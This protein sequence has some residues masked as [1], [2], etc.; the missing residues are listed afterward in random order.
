MLFAFLENI[1]AKMVKIQQNWWP[2][3]PYQEIT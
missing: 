2:S 1:L 3:D